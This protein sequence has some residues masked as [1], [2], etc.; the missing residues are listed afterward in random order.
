LIF[1]ATGDLKN[2]LGGVIINKAVSRFKDPVIL[3]VQVYSKSE[4]QE[5]TNHDTANE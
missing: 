5:E 3:K 1:T 4:N 2:R